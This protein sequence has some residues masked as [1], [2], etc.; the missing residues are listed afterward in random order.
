MIFREDTG[1]SDEDRG[2][3]DEEGS[4]GSSGSGDDSAEEEDEL[5]MAV[6]ALM[7]GRVQEDT[8]CSD[9]DATEARLASDEGVKLAVSPVSRDASADICGLETEADPLLHLRWGFSRFR[10]EEV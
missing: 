2:S 10:L 9:D 1:L 3:R 8:D 5:D 6:A 4:D 7:S